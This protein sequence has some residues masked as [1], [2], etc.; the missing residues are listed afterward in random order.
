VVPLFGKALLSLAVV[1]AVLYL[2][3]WAVWKAKSASGG[4]V[5]SVVVNRVVVAPEKGNREEYF[6]DGTSTVSCSQ[7]LFPWT[8][9]GACWY[10]ERHRTIEER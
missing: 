6:A 10:V 8:G 9:A 4:G 2:G 5:G 1:V 7:S 3:D